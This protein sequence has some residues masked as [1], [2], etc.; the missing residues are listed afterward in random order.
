MQDVSG[1]DGGGRSVLDAE[2]HV[3]LFQM[4]VH[5]AG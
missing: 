4:L 5:R 2:L 3:D 1:L